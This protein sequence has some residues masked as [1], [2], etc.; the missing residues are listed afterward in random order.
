MLWAT[1]SALGNLEYKWVLHCLIF[2]WS[3]LTL[4]TGSYIWNAAE[5][6]V[7]FFRLSFG[8]FTTDPSD[9][10]LTDFSRR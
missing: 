4:S 8:R 10:M 2:D 3:A 5:N 6:V 1:S 9:T 7:E